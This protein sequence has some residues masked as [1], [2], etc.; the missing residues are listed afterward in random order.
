M[1]IHNHR[2]RYSTPDKN[3]WYYSFC[4]TN[5]RPRPS[6]I[7]EGKLSIFGG[8]VTQV[9]KKIHSFIYIHT[10]KLCGWHMAS[11]WFSRC[12]LGSKLLY[13]VENELK[14]L[15]NKNPV[16]QWEKFSRKG[17]PFSDLNLNYYPLIWFYIG[18]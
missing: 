9:G 12:S 11:A 3:W 15:F 13:Y 2:E 5:W 4:K 6:C 18:S 14:F 1:Q 8:G 17:I 16:E 7:A 10:Y